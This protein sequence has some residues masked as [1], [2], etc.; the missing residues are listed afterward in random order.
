MKIE[1]SRTLRNIGNL[2]LTRRDFLKKGGLIAAGAATAL[3]IPGIALAFKSPERK[4]VLKE[5]G[6][7]IYPGWIEN[8]ISS[9]FIQK[10]KGHFYWL[11]EA[12]FTNP[13]LTDLTKDYY[14]Y[15]TANEKA[16]NRLN[17]GEALYHA[18]EISYKKLSEQDKA[19]VSSRTSTEFE[20]LHAGIVVF[21]AG[22]MPWF[23]EQDLAGLGVSLND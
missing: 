23:K 11:K 20:A 1:A 21:A 6:K 4:P 14:S 22:F 13:T 17:P 9:D 16:K 8:G 12:I 2:R 18:I 15:L 7:D 10:D 19:K 3:S 5:E